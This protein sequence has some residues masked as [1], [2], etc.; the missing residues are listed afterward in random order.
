[1]TT[2]PR[3]TRQRG[4][5]GQPH[6]PAPGRADPRHSHDVRHLVVEAAEQQGDELVE[7]GVP[8]PQRQQPA[9]HHT[10]H[11]LPDLRDR[12]PVSRWADS[13]E[14]KCGARSRR[15]ARGR[16]R[17][18]ARVPG[19]LQ[20]LA[21]LPARSMLRPDPLLVSDPPAPSTVVS[22]AF[23]GEPAGRGCLN[24]LLATCWESWGSRRGTRR[25]AAGC[26]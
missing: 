14:G 6:R 13:T 5:G 12:K 4:R 17:G 7:E 2:N 18:R 20:A 23:C 21:R 3:D 10:G 1:M 22:A 19:L 8:V 26:R 9:A 24:Q 25:P 11:R 15:T 16:G